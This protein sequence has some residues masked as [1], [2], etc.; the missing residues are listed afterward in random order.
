ML[1][2]TRDRRF[3][4]VLLDIGGRTRLRARRG[5][6]YKAVDPLTCATLSEGELRRGQSVTLATKGGGALILGE[7]R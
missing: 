6:S 4:T 3:V 2:A 7:W 5:L 1:T